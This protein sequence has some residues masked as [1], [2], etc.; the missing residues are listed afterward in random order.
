MVLTMSVG[1][2]DLS[3]AM[4][5]ALSR[6]AELPAV[7]RRQ[8]DKHRRSNLLRIGSVLGNILYSATP[9]LS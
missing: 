5:G 7:S 4:I 9:T 1:T 3:Q 2:L 8:P 6:R